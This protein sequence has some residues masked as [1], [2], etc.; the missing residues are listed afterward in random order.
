MLLLKAFDEGADGI[1]VSGCHPNDCHYTS[2]NFHARRRWIM[3]RSLCD[4]MGIDTRRI[5]F[6][7]VSAA[8]GAKWAEIVNSTVASI[9][10][11]GPYDDYKNIAKKPVVEVV[12][13]G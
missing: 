4:F 7:W 6:S 3:F 1:M 11:L 5:I 10:E 13:H 2:G 8:E 12:N 9:R